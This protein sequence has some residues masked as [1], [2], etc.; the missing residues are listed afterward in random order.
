MGNKFFKMNTIVKSGL[1]V[2][3]L[4][5][6]ITYSLANSGVYKV[7]EKTR[8]RVLKSLEDGKYFLLVSPQNGIFEVKIISYEKTKKNIVV[9]I[10]GSVGWDV[11]FDNDGNIED[12]EN[13]VGKRIEI[14]RAEAGK[15]L[16]LENSYLREHQKARTQ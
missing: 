11:D 3:A 7:H 14:V 9:E 6:S 10:V 13:L 2:L 16:E 15:I 1:F 8:Y 12:V 4:M 5:L